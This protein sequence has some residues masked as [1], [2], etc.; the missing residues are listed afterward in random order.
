MKRWPIVVALLVV[1]AGVTA[2]F[3]FI[4]GEPAT[5]AEAVARAEKR[6]DVLSK[7]AGLSDEEL[8][9]EQ[10]LVI[11]K[12]RVA[13]TKWPDAPETKAAALKVAQL[14]RQWKR[15]EEALEA[16]K[17]FA[18]ADGD[19]T[20][21]EITEKDLGRDALALWEAFAKKWKD[22]P[23][24]ADAAWRVIELKAAMGPDMVAP[25]EILDA[26]K[27][28]CETYPASEH[29]AKAMLLRA[30][31]LRK[32]KE[33]DAALK[34]FDRI[35]EE[36]EGKPAAAKAL[37]E[38]GKI[39]AEQDKP[40]E[41]KEALD[42]LERKY[43][44]SDEAKKGGGVRESAEKSAA[45]KDAQEKERDFFKERYGMPGGDFAAAA[46]M[47]WEHLEPLLKQQIDLIHYDIDATVD[48]AAKTLKATCTLKLRND[49]D[50]KKSLLLAILPTMKISKASTGGADAKVTQDGDRVLV[51]LPAPLARGAELSIS[52]EWSGTDA[53]AGAPLRLGESGY[54]APGA[55]WYPATY[56]G[57]VH[58]GAVELHAPGEVRTT[59]G[60]Q[61][62]IGLYFAYGQ[63]AVHAKAKLSYLCNDAA[64]AAATLDRVADIV[65]FY[66]TQFGPLPVA[67]LAFVDADL[68]PFIGGVSPAGMILLNGDFMKTAKDPASLLAHEIAHQ[69]FG[70]LVPVSIGRQDY[71]PW[72]SEGLASQADAMY[73][74][75][76]FG[77]ERAR[78]HLEKG[79][80]VYIHRMQD[81]NDD[82][83]LKCWSGHPEYPAVVYL[84]GAV[85][86]E[87]LRA[88]LGPAYAAGLR[89]WTRDCAHRESGIHDFRAAL[90]AEA[91][92]DLKA[93]FTQWIENP[94]FPRLRVRVEGSTLVVTQEVRAF[95]LSLD[96]DI[97][98]TI[99]TL[100]LSKS[101]ERF[102]LG[103]APSKVVLDPKGRLLKLPGPGN[104]WSR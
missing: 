99:Q 51:T 81:L 24:A 38:K 70:N 68:P 82:A 79:A 13:G 66:E 26:T 101:E 7:M 92:R 104:E 31:T 22:D 42:E 21:A 60:S 62:A 33:T 2:A 71:T 41:A 58:T 37:L 97:D 76:A 46:R 25:I 85:V 56:I 20:A 8:K 32:V 64:R 48:P 86:A 95:A 52:F 43:P 30:E 103:K 6:L 102:E 65:A 53:G 55:A 16:F 3:L 50:A 78:H 84:K 5:P 39:L 14:L 34:E 80:Q 23:R 98:G 96:V 91:K 90:E 1:A 88:E 28:F 72:L 12:F 87:M 89:R 47:R 15:F 45:E 57:D 44:G 49:G 59:D 69:W 35:I 100:T 17:A 27:A 93:W 36:F 18:T 67:S 77:P 19:W 94:G 73:L 4:E 29:R 11:A 9:K 40:K 54:S 61:P 10:D 75:K 63:Y 74:E 83:L